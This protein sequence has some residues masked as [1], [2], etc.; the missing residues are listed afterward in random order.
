MPKTPV[1]PHRWILAIVG[2]AMSALV[3]GLGV[4]GARVL[5]AS[6]QNAPGQGR[7]L[8]VLH[9]GAQNN[10][11]TNDLASVQSCINEAATGGETVFFPPGRY[12]IDGTLTISANNLVLMGENNASTVL[13]EGNPGTTLIRVLHQGQVVNKTTIRDLSLQTSVPSSGGTLISLHNAWRTYL[14]NLSF[15]STT[16]LYKMGVGVRANGGNQ[17]FIQDSRFS[18][19]TTEAVDTA[20]IGDVYLTDLEVNLAN[21]HTSIGVVFNSATGGIY[22]TNVNVTSGDIGWLFKNTLP[23]LPPPNYG[24]FTNCLADT[25]NG[26]GWDFQSALSMV[27]T[28]DWASSATT[29]GILA[30][31]VNGLVIASSRIYNNG[32]SGVRLAPGATNVSIRGSRIAGNSRL[33]NG[34]HSGIHVLAGTSNFTIENNTIGMADGFANTQRDGI[35]IA[36]GN[37]GS[38]MVE[39]NNLL[40]NQHLGLAN[41]ASGSFQMVSGN[42]SN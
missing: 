1:S 31:G 16:Q 22:A 9:C 19:P 4:E 34:V 7:I 32:A 12:K 28:N 21:D 18:Y 24:F 42:L 30:Q 35:K 2:L 37:G 17:L 27:L 33:A 14:Q 36:T 10:G 5:A 23:G 15:G 40:N 20:A 3:F 11:T 39:G 29:N 26:I 13:L 41:G 25:Q 6:G 8:N 38:F